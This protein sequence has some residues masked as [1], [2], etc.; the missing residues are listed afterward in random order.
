[1]A[2]EEKGKK[3][4]GIVKRIFKW[5]GLGLLALLLIASIT[6]QAP[7]KVITLL[8]VFL[9]ACTVLP[10]PYRKWFWMGIGVTV[11]AL[12]IWVF[13]P[14]RKGDWKP[15][16]FDEELAALEAKR[17]IPD[18]ENAAIIYNELLDRYDSN[19]FYAGLPESELKKVPMWEPWSTK[20]YPEIAEWLQKQEGIIETLKETSKIEKCRFPISCDIFRMDES[21]DRLAAMR[22]WAYLLIS[23][24]NNDMA[25]DRI[26]RALEKNLTILQMG[27]HQCQQPTILD[28]VVGIAVEALATRQFNRFIV[29]GDAT[30]A[31][32]SVIEKALADIKHDWSYDLPRILEGEKLMAKNTV[33]YLAYEIN[34]KGKIRHIRNLAAMLSQSGETKPKLN[35]WQRKL[36]KASVVL[37]WFY[38]PSTP[39]KAAK[40]IDESFEKLYAMAEPDF[41]WDKQLT[42]PSVKFR[43]NFRYLIKHMAS[44]LEQ[45]YYRIH[46][47]YLRVLSGQRG[48][49]LLIA[50]RRYKN[51][52]GHWPESLDDIKSLAP[53]EI[54]VDPINGSSFIYKLTDENFILYS[55]GKNNIDEGGKRDKWDE[56]KTGADDWLIW[57]PRSRKSKEKKADAEQD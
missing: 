33:C 2:K 20:D 34:P 4:P 12:I 5:I 49:R 6:F 25:E 11:I 53:E 47:L 37:R 28:M 14:D 40:I 22:R 3:K 21:M 45:P 35:Y 7:W 26:P 36:F 44:F 32:L 38:M 13:L 24:A 43:F 19:S 15:Y 57:P 51:K 8:V 54:F 23:A 10:K 52:N 16:T 39:Q 46:D 31:H 41:D 29:T 1:M 55:K 50:L 9:L 48:S 18:E 30:E 56:E 17:A 27:N 42:E